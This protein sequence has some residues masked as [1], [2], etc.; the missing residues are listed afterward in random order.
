L[1]R[2]GRRAAEPTHTI[3]LKLE[4]VAN[5]T[6][7]RLRLDAGDGTAPREIEVKIPAGVREGAKIRVAGAAGQQDLYLLVHIVPH[8]RFERVDDDLRATVAV[9]LTTAVLGGEVEVPTLDGR[10]SI[11]VPP[12]TPAGR[13]FRVRGQGLPTRD[14]KRGDLLASLS[15]ELPKTLDKRAQELFEELRGLGH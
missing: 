4:E 5:G 11:K 14:G 8:A 9:P 1:G 10:V 2:G 15:I 12:A 3:D 13:T 7:R 6:T